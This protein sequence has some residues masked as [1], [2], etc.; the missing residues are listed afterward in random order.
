MDFV[1]SGTCSEKKRMS[2]MGPTCVPDPAC[3]GQ[4]RWGPSP[5]TARYQA[6][7]LEQQHCQQRNNS[8]ANNKCDMSANKTSQQTKAVFRIRN[9]FNADPDPGPAY[10]VT[11]DPVPAPLDLIQ[12]FDDKNWKKITAEKNIYFLLEFAYSQD[13]QATG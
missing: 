1:K 3:S 4:R 10:Q 9:V 5:L 7:S 2:G 11:A 12:G 13:V 8:I 6:T